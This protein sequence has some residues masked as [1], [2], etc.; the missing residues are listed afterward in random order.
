MKTDS[1]NVH[2][3]PASLWRCYVSIFVRS[4]G[5]KWKTEEVDCVD[6]SAAYRCA[7]TLK[8][9]NPNAVK[10]VPVRAG[11]VHDSEGSPIVRGWAE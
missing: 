4:D 6:L 5:G 1:Q 9:A 3:F 11:F 7:E 8:R 10:A 2:K